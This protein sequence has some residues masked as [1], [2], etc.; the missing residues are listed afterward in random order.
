MHI[1]LQSR[2]CSE[3]LRVNILIFVG[4]LSFLL[5]TLPAL[6]LIGQET[7]AHA[8]EECL[9]S[10]QNPMEVLEKSLP[11]FQENTL[12]PVS[13]HSGQEIKTSTIY[14]VLTGYSSTEDQT[15]S[16]P[17]IT[18]SGSCVGEG[19]IAAN[20]L[21]FGTEVKIPSLYGDRIF[22][23]EDRMHPRNDYKIDVWFPTRWQALDFGVKRT[24]VEV[25]EG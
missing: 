15:D 9:M 5:S 18:A 22:V 13:S 12:M 4:I 2:I 19:T 23:V 8:D 7:Q 3:R 14:V 25:S 1:N 21:P 17:F 10:E 20:F 16:T 24:Y 11:L 6:E